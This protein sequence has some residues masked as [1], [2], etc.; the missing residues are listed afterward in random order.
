MQIPGDFSRLSLDHTGSLLG[1]DT[2]WS[3]LAK[4][5]V[6]IFTRAGQLVLDL[7]EADLATLQP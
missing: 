1:V 5:H 2:T 7:G 6:K 4:S 3:S